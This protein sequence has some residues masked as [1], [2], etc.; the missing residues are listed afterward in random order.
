M[1]KTIHSIMRIQ[2]DINLFSSVKRNNNLK[3]VWICT[4]HLYRAVISEK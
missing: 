3:N 1:T 4:H 2:N